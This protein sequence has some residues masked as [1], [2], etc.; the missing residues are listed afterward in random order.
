MILQ[1]LDINKTSHKI[2]TFAAGRSTLHKIVK[3]RKEK[4]LAGFLLQVKED[5]TDNE[6]KQDH[7]MPPLANCKE[8]V[9]LSAVVQGD[10]RVFVDKKRNSLGV[11]DFH[12]SPSFVFS[13]GIIP[14]DRQVAILRLNSFKVTDKLGDVQGVAHGVLFSVMDFLTKLIVTERADRYNE[15]II[16]TH[17]RPARSRESYPRLTFADKS[18]GACAPLFSTCAFAPCAIPCT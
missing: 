6:E 3:P 7:L 15:F 4:P 9:T 13:V 12:V 18:W 11:V 2:Y 8:S 17:S 16:S 1:I 10:R 14:K 5:Q